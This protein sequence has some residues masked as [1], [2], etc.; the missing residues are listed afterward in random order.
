MKRN[1]ADRAPL[2]PARDQSG[3]GTA[4][5]LIDVVNPF[6]FEGGADARRRVEAIARPLANLRAGAYRL[7]VP[8]IYVNDNF[9]E[10][11]SERSQLLDRAR[12]MPGDGLLDPRHDDYFIIKPQF[13]GF[14]ATNLG[15]LL[16]KL[17]IRRLIL[18]GIATEICVLFTAAD[19][20]MRD[21]GLW[22]PSDA[23]APLDMAQGEGALA[24]MRSAMQAETAPCSRLSLADWLDR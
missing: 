23:V 24:V 2:A 18:T 12:P 17:G 14:Y 19:A 8:V 3:N 6:E 4:L 15:V 11:H 5:L 7:G 22:V 16:P 13:S 9:G 1:L 20:H 21:Y 10:W